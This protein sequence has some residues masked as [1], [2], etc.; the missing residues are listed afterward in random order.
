[1]VEAVVL[2]SWTM[3]AVLAQRGDYGIAVPTPLTTTVVLMMM[4]LELSA[5]QV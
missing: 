4:T 1:M 5:S 2:Y 3:S